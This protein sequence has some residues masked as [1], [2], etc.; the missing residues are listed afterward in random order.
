MSTDDGAVPFTRLPARDGARWLRDAATMLRAAPG[1]WLVLLLAYYLIQI[2]LSLVPVAGPLALIVLRP[3]FTVGFLAAA[4]S[5]ERGELPEI[6]HLFRGFQSNL[7]ALIPIG[8]FMLFGS[9]LALFA[10]VTIDGGELLEALVANKTMDDLLAGPRVEQAMLVASLCALPVVLAEWFAP[11]LVVFNGCGAFRSLAASLR[12]ALANWRP[13]VVYAMLLTLFGAVLPGLAV[14]LVALA[15]PLVAAR[16]VVAL[17]IVPYVFLFVT[18]QA[19]SDYVG[20]RAIFHADERPFAPD[21]P[22]ADAKA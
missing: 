5:Q 15:L 12:A 9:A 2:V 17:V 13:V 21:A 7:W 20:F 19:I 3:V 8:V 22:G 6:A 10:T 11:A 1:R 18:A 4:W 14:K 16:I